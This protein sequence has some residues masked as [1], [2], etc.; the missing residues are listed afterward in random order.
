MRLKHAGIALPDIAS[1]HQMSVGS[2]RALLGHGRVDKSSKDKHCVGVC[3]ED[4]QAHMVALRTD[5]G[6]S[7]REIMRRT[8]WSYSTVYRT[9]RGA[10]DIRRDKP[11][12][13]FSETEDAELR[14]L[15]EQ[16][17]L[18]WEQ[19]ATRMIGRTGKTCKNRYYDYVKDRGV[20][21]ATPVVDNITRPSKAVQLSSTTIR[22]TSGHRPTVLQTSVPHS[23]CTHSTV[24]SKASTSR[25]YYSTIPPGT[26]F[27]QA[28]DDIILQGRREKTPLSK[29]AAE[30]GRSRTSVHNR[31]YR[32][33]LRERRS[34]TMK[35]SDE[36][37]AELI[38]SL[39]AGMTRREVATQH[40]IP[41]G[42]LKDH[43]RRL[44][45]RLNRK[46]R[47]GAV[48]QDEDHALI[49]AMRLDQGLTR[50][51]ISRRTGFSDS[52]ISRTLRRFGPRRENKLVPYSAVEDIQLCHLREHERLT[53]KEVAAKMKGRN[54]HS[55]KHRYNDSLKGRESAGTMSVADTNKET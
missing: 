43:L 9:L 44:K 51:E 4:E 6:L 25:R 39:D 27:S 14:R 17:G 36:Q 37:A 21:V 49:F 15:Y 7:Y 24:P 45:I 20:A 52:T 11:R 55:C 10:L 18:T 26:Y 48:C 8:G 29:M 34:R 3:Q 30:L 32:G 53:W 12:P 35:F 19:V 1:Q 13:R 31:M 23:M 22:G 2:L 54:L 41:Y 38:R 40:D 16:E 33:L 5:Q 47:N 42:Q 46:S 28:E 50:G